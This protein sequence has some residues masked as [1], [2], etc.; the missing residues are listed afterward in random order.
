MRLSHLVAIAL[1]CGLSVACVGGSS[2]GGGTGTGTATGTGT[3]SGSDAGST[4]GTDT[5]GGGTAVN[6]YP[7]GA[8]VPVEQLAATMTDMM[9]KLMV[10][11][12]DL[13]SGKLG[14]ATVEGCKAF[15][16]SKLKSWGLPA[17]IKAGKVKYDATQAGKCLQ[18]MGTKCSA[19]SSNAEEPAACKATFIGTIA[20]GG[21]CTEDQECI[22]QNCDHPDSNCP[23]KCGKA[24]VAAGGAC[25]DPAECGSNLTCKDKK[26]VA[27]EIAAVGAS[28]AKAECAKGA[29]CDYSAPEAPI[30]KAAGGADATCSDD[31]GCLP[32]FYCHG[33]GFP[34]G[35]CK[36]RAKAGEPCATGMTSDGAQCQTTHVCVPGA[37]GKATCLPRVKTGGA[38]TSG[39][40]CLGVDLTCQGGTCKVL[41]KKGEAC[42][43]PAA[44]AGSLFACM[45][46]AVC[47]ESKCGDPPGEGKP[48][49]LFTGCAEG[50]ACDGKVCKTPPKAPGKG[51]AC[52][53]PC[54]PGLTCKFDDKGKGTCQAPVCDA[55]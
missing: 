1:V 42:A 25:A 27:A 48:C 20:E 55:P 13:A 7:S 49:D 4:G 33:S 21:A 45:P 8:P 24:P 52:E 36:P 5:T 19:F 30:C 31:A 51:E 2:S 26:C 22:S 44:S 18:A 16:G 41:P 54:Q 40:Q 12:Q 17:L 6:A 15:S 39:E 23:G 53:G 38:C 11:C 14:F 35:T 37:D 47:V 28:C 32:E 3:G 34:S 29:T 46:P 50:L 43:P 10:A 9:C